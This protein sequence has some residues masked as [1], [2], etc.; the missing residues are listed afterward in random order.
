[1][2]TTTTYSVS[3]FIALATGF[4]IGYL[5]FRSKVYEID[6]WKIQSKIMRISGQPTPDRAQVNKYTITYLALIFEELAET[7]E[8]VCDAMARGC[9]LVRPTD[10]NQAHAAWHAQTPSV[11]AVHQMLRNMGH[12]LSAVSKSLRLSNER[13]SES[14]YVPMTR[15]EAKDFADGVTDVM[16]TTCGVTIASGIP[17]A[18][19]YESVGYSNLSKADP[20]TGLILKDASGKWIKGPNYV[21]PNIERVLD[22]YEAV[23]P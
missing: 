2:I 21:P 18:S 23:S 22:L 14:F 19:C 13:L 9:G 11:K 4:A 12:D 3:L 8:P 6:P 5:L 10:P 16:V 15:M 1:M 7:I 17:G 20:I